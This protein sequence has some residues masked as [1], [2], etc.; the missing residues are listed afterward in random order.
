MSQTPD[1]PPFPSDQIRPPAPSV[2]T[3]GGTQLLRPD[4]VRVRLPMVNAYLLGLPGEPWVLVDA[5]MPLTAPMIRAAIEKHHAGRPPAAIVLTH[6]HLDHIGG[7]HDLLEEWKVPVYAHP[8]ELPYLTGQ[9]PY[10]FPDPTVGGLMSLLSPAFV[11]GPFDFRPQI[12]A[13]PE[14][15]GVPFL[16]DWRWLHTPGHSV[17]HVSLWRESDRTL[18]AGDAFVTTKQESAVGALTL[19][20]VLVHRPPAYYTPNWDAA[21]ESVRALAALS[22]ALAATGH[23][24][25]MAGTHM[26]AALARLAR[27]FDEAARPVRGWYL[28]HPVPVTLPQAGTRDPLKTLVLGTLAVA[29]AALVWRSLRRD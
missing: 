24:H 17:G 26:D 12:Q 18:I 5:G 1:T 20:P 13:L 11:P 19:K 15:G 28:N 14:G 8:L 23:G 3:F 21:R 29:G 22:P 2:S 7:L 9:V 6:G 27:N 16:P 25:P 10:P 4:V